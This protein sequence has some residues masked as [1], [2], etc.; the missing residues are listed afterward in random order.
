MAI[1]ERKNPNSSSKLGLRRN[2]EP[3]MR[4]SQRSTKT[5]NLR[6]HRGIFHSNLL[7]QRQR[8]PL[9][10]LECDKKLSNSAMVQ[11]MLSPLQ[12]K[13]LPLQKKQ[14]DYFVHLCEH[15][16]KCEPCFSSLTASDRKTESLPSVRARISALSSSK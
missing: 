10:F 9:L 5:V 8:H 15:T 12:T 2:V 16:E 1:M 4:S 6:Q 3:I 13:H 14:A 11:S 7:S